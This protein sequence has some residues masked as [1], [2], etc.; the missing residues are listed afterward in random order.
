MV[1]TI[2]CFY[3]ITF[4]IRLQLLRITFTTFIFPY[5]LCKLIHAIFVSITKNYFHKNDKINWHP[6]LTESHSP[7]LSEALATFC[8]DI[9]VITSLV[10]RVSG[11]IKFC[12]DTNP[13]F[14]LCYFHPSKSVLVYFRWKMGIVIVSCIWNWKVNKRTVIK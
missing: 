12:L 5:L 10:L 13:S 3:F 1:I 6:L 8:D 7:L 11:K 14:S 4:V 9:I 2:H